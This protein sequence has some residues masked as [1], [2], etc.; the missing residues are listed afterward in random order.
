MGRED[1]A[2]GVRFCALDLET[3]YT[4]PLFDGAVWRRI[5]SK[6]PVWLF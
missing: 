5:G 1:W 6:N 3:L 4:L 2:D